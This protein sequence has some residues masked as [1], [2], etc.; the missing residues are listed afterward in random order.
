VVAF[1]CR[2]WTRVPWLDPLFCAFA[3]L[4][5]DLWLSVVCKFD[6]DTRVSSQ[7]IGK[8]DPARWQFL[9]LLLAERLQ[10]K[11]RL[12]PFCC[13]SFADAL[14]HTFHSTFGHRTGL[15]HNATVCYKFYSY[16]HYCREY[17]RDDKWPTYSKYFTYKQW[18]VHQDSNK[19]SCYMAEDTDSDT[20]MDD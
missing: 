6:M 13:N 11:S 2:R 17:T 10:R 1:V 7:R 4:P 8:L 15:E 16:G 19:Y 12:K 9:Q 18:Y 5:R 3:E 14:E 20:D